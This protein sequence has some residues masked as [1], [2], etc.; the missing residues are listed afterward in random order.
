[1]MRTTARLL[2]ERKSETGEGW[3]PVV[4]CNSIEYARRVAAAG[5][6]CAATARYRVVH[7][8]SGKGFPLLRRAVC[9][10]PS[11]PAGAAA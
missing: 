6:R 4:S 1:M 9:K 5:V 7:V 2:V 3:T 8:R 10:K 11:E